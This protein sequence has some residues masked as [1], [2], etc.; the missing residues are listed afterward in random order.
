MVSYDKR[1]AAARS[2]L[3]LYAFITVTFP[4][5]HR[6]FIPLEGKLIFSPFDYHSGSVD[7][8]LSDLFCPAHQFAQS[9]TSPAIA[10]QIFN[11]QI[12]FFFLRIG[13]HVEHFVEPLR[14]FSTRAPPQ[15]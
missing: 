11:P 10:R 5:A 8:N 1:K 6:D 7:S 2:I 14:S 9:T 4:L 3:V 15:A 13:N 12:T